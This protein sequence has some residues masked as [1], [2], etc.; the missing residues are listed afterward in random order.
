M[1]GNLYSAPVTNAFD[2]IDGSYTYDTAGSTRFIQEVNLPGTPYISV[3]FP[4]LCP[5]SA[6]LFGVVFSTLV[7]S[8]M[9][10]PRNLTATTP[11]RTTLPPALSSM[12]PASPATL[13]VTSC[14]L[15]PLG[16]SPRVFNDKLGVPPALE[17]R[18]L[19]PTSARASVVSKSKIPILSWFVS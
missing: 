7:S 9:I 19:V 4:R 2:G 10:L 3:R 16:P 8:G 5:F 18:P 17:P 1:T 6:P 12:T 13:T 14:I 15:R 11:R